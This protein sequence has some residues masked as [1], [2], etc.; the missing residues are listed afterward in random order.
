MKKTITIT[1]IIMI[2]A[3]LFIGDFTLA[4]NGNIVVII[5]KSRAALNRNQ[6]KN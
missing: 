2:C 1:F 3:G 4:Q 6:I 5:N